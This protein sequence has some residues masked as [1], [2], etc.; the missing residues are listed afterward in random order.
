MMAAG[1]VKG[2][3]YLCGSGGGLTVEFT[4]GS[5]D[6]LVDGLEYAADG[7]DHFDADFR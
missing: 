7:R 6:M 3:P 2:A 4:A 1:F 5:F